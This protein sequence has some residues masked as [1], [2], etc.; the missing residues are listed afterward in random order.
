MLSKFA[1]GQPEPDRTLYRSLSGLLEYAWLGEIDKA[2]SIVG[3]RTVGKQ[4]LNAIDSLTGMNALHIAVGRDNLAMARLLVEAGIAFIP[5][6]EGRF[7]ST[8]AAI[9][10]VSDELNDYIVEAEEMA[11]P[12]EDGGEDNV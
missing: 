10:E 4:F 2:R 6:N 1:S 3:D 8:I 7:P 9:C 12:A 11:L 5:D